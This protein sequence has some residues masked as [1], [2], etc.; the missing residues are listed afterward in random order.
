MGGLGVVGDP[1]LIVLAAPR[2]HQRVKRVPIGHSVGFG[3][4]TRVASPIGRAHHAQ[5]GGPLA[6]FARRDCRISVACGQ[7]ADRGP[8][9]VGQPLARPA[10]SGE[11]GI[12]QLADRHR[13]QRFLDRHVD[14]GA[15]LGREYRVHAGASG[16]QSADKGRLFAN[17]ADRR[18]GEIV[19]LSGQQPG[20]AAAE[21]QGQVGRGIVGPWP[22]LSEGGDINERRRRVA[23]AQS[24][25]VILASQEIIG[26]AFAD[27]QIGHRQRIARLTRVAGNDRLA[28]VEVLRE[29]YRQARVDG[30]DR[31]AHIGQKASAHGG[32]QAIADLND[33]QFRQQRHW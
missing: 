16:G 5:P 13:R 4:K 2:R 19:D 33:P 24:G 3:R 9:A 10:L 30:G 27:D 6:V 22:R 31:G 21:E 32:G 28:V 1:L 8:V 18:F 20:D 23:A 7:N 29:R 17:R 14:H 26:P 11:P 15:G 12:R 25:D